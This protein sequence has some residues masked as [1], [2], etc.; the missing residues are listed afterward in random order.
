MSGC[1]NPVPPNGGDKD[2]AGPVIVSI[3]SEVL[4]T[5]QK[6]VVIAFDENITTSGA[7]LT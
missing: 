7:I 2:T 5:G 1:A 3:E 4:K 6:R